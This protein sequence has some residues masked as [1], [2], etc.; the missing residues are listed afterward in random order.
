MREGSD[1]PAPSS[2]AKKSKFVHHSQ[3]STPIPISL[4]QMR[5]REN[6]KIQERHAESLS[7]NQR[8]QLGSKI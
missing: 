4:L 8:T 1:Q 5:D 2:S 6:Y 7:K 3:G